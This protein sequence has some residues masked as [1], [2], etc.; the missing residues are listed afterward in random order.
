MNLAG[1]GV[2]LIYKSAKKPADKTLFLAKY[3]VTCNK[4]AVSLGAKEKK[5]LCIVTGVSAPAR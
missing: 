5:N 2:R 3:D 1:D 4:V